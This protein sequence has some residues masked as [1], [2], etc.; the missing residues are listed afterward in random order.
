M[1]RMRKVEEVHSDMGSGAGIAGYQLSFVDLERK[2]DVLPVTG[3]KSD[4]STFDGAIAS[5]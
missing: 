3:S 5:V 2:G 1:R 4:N